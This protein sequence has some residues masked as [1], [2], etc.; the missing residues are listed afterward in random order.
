VI[1]RFADRYKN[2]VPRRGARFVLVALKVMETLFPNCWIV[3]L[4]RRIVRPKNRPKHTQHTS[5]LGL[6][7][8]SC[9]QSLQLMRY[10]L[11]PTE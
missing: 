9:C 6:A 1:Q 4:I 8:R 2:G 5:I 11:K 10:E 7:Q 3:E